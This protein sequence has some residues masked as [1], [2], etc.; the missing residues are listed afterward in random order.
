MGTDRDSESPFGE[1]IFSYTSKEAVEDGILFDLHS[2]KGCERLPINYITTNLMGKGYFKED[3]KGL[4][5]ANLQDL[6]VQCLIALKKRLE[7]DFVELSVELP[8]GERETVWMKP[9]EDNGWTVMLPE[10]D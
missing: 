8:S 9:N 6:I 10:D 2:V 1:I 7:S 3:C 5:I 4:N